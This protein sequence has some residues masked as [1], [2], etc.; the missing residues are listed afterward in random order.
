V[1][2]RTGIPAA[3]AGFTLL[4][5]LLAMVLGALLLGALA[6]VSR[7]TL[8]THDSVS[9]RQQLNRAALASMQRITRAATASPGLLLP[10]QDNPATA[11]NAENIRSVLAVREDPT[12]DLDG[13]GVP[14]ADN[15]G[16][17]RIDED[18]PAD[19][20]NDGAPGIVGIDDD[21]DGTVDESGIT[22]S[23]DESATIDDDPVNGLD[24]DGDGSVDEDPGADRNGDG[25][26]GI[27]GIDDNGDGVVDNGSVNDDDEDGRSDE[28]WIDPV[29]FY[30][31]GTQLVLR[32]P[33]PWDQDGNGQVDGRDFMETVLTDRVETFRVQRL[34][35]P[36][37][38]VALVDVT[39]TLHDPDS[40]ERMTVSTR[41]RI[42]SAS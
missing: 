16:D 39:L 17:G 5:L 13:N 25:C 14:D 12:T 37:A 11:T 34:P 42:G 26:P 21:N 8:A 7:L 6:S 28:D 3:A 22:N 18:P 20:T 40:G 31:R 35:D 23:D 15:D 41:M 9:A 19:I 38:G 27:C 33:V 2:R 24:D 29:V 36:A 1:N 30:Q 10:L 32:T 4:E